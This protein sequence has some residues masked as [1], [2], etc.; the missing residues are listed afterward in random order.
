MSE[1]DHAEIVAQLGATHEK[2][3]LKVLKDLEDQ[4]AALVMDAPLVDGKLS[5]LAWATQQRV[6]IRQAFRD[7]F[8][9]DA[10]T[11]VRE[12][13]TIVKSLGSMYE[14]YGSFLNI[15]NDVLNALKSV[16]YQGFQDIGNTFANELAD[17]LYQNTL[18]GKPVGDSIKSVRQKI[19]GIYME[20]DQAEVNR[21][22]KIAEK[23]GKAGEEAVEALHRVYAA[24]RTGRNMRRY[25][26]Q[27]VHDNMM[28]FDAGLN[29][30][31]GKEIG[32]ENWKYYG[33]VINDSRPFCQTHAGQVMSEDEIREL[34]AST[35]W[36]GKAQGDPFIVRGGYNCR[37]H[38]RPAFGDEV[39][40]VEDA[41][42]QPQK[43]EAPA[44]NRQEFNI[45]D[46]QIRSSEHLAIDTWTG[47]DDAHIKRAYR[48]GIVYNDDRL[49]EIFSE[50]Q[51]SEIKAM[52][53]IFADYKPNS[54]D[55][56]Y[57][58]MYFED[59]DEFYAKM[60]NLSVGDILED[61]AP[62]SW[63]K[64]LGVARE[65]TGEGEDFLNGILIKHKN[66]KG[67]DIEKMSAF[68]DEREV[69]VAPS[70]LKIAKKYEENGVIVFEVE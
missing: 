56:I 2:R 29:V 64:D 16:S 7:T 32:A 40:A 62:A 57:R 25:A 21:L 67:Y 53:K 45:D 9:K 46:V 44:D 58:G 3:L 1:L 34:W 38:F 6:Q 69:L 30:A 59:G 48:D 37:H 47:G 70:K 27:M 15:D 61:S 8:L 66:G 13:D 65:F 23:G 35:S 4:I 41:P 63:S 18:V 49:N 55:E 11:A 43:P 31:A 50:S 17:E 14:E 26:S 51:I 33:S 5:D 39:G 12:Y 10:D 42:K 54:F 19:N 22:V 68:A 60:S 28:Q 20:S 52:D 24:D 36:A